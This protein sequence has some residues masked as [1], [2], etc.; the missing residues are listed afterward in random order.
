MTDY[1]GAF[2]AFSKSE[3]STKI[4][5]RFSSGF[6]LGG[7]LSESLSANQMS[8]NQSSLST[9]SWSS[10]RFLESVIFSIMSLI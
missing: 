8:A 9:E 6:L 5:S 7:A 1:E 2:S 10:R 3:I 4:L